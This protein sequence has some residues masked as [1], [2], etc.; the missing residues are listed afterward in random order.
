MAQGQTAAA[1]ITDVDISDTPEGL[2]I[3][4]VSDRPLAIGTSRT[5]GNALIAD[6]LNATL[7][8][9]DEATVEQFAPAE[10]IALV[11]LTSLPDGTVRMSITGTDGPPTAQIDTA[12]GNLVFNIA[13]G[14]AQ[15]DGAEDAI[16]IGVTGQGQ[17]DYRV[18]NAAIG[19]RTDTP[20][21]DLPFSVQ[22]VPQELLED[23]QVQSV[24]EALRTVVGVPPATRLSQLLRAMSFAGFRVEIFCAMDCAMTPTLPP[25]S[26]FLTLSELRF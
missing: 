18:P 5:E 1:V 11:Q 14:V 20:L 12:A 26:R 22:V 24:N 21:R 7:E 19:S 4:L 23:R 3:E 6:I 25:A 17:Q 10:G 9:T 13:P 2:R 8:L 16:Q 15:L